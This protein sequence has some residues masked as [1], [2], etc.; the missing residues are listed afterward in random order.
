MT[1]LEKVRETFLSV[2]IGTEFSTAE[3]KQMVSLKFKT[4][5]NSVIP[6]DYSYNMSN[7]GKIGS[8][9]SFNIFIQIKRGLYKYVGENY[10]Y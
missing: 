3:I 7:K 1:V 2:P 8:L 6:S 10:E 9:E 4:N 5:P